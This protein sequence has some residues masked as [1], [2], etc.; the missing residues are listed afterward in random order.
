MNR[1]NKNPDTK[2]RSLLVEIEDELPNQTDS[3]YSLSSN[4]QQLFK[5]Q[6]LVMDLHG[7]QRDELPDNP[8]PEVKTRKLLKKKR[9]RPDLDQGQ[10]QSAGSLTSSSGSSVVPPGPEKQEEFFDA[11]ESYHNIQENQISTTPN[12]PN[13]TSKPTDTPE[14]MRPQS[15]PQNTTNQTSTTPNRLTI[16]SKDTGNPEAMRPQSTPQNTTQQTST[17]TN[18]LNVT[19]KHTGNPEAIRLATP[20]NTPQDKAEERIAVSDATTTAPA[21]QDTGT[22]RTPLTSAVSVL[23]F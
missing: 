19:S 14:A 11:H 5:N 2:G 17:T 10:D 21:T 8:L 3:D 16:T 9:P 23:S 12:R 22:G 20:Q 15:T 4:D 13:V 6:A 1:K 18:R 7:M